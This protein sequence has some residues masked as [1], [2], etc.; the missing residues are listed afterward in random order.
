MLPTKFL[1][2]PFVLLFAVGCDSTSTTNDDAVSKAA[3][4]KQEEQAATDKRI[5]AKKAE[6]LAKD[7]AKEDAIVAKQA[8]VDAICVLPEKL[9][10]KLDKACDEVST[11]HDAFMVRLY[12]EKPETIEKWT[13]GKT[14]QLSMTVAQCK[15]AGSLEVAACQAHALT[16]AGA[17]IKKELPAIFRTCIEKFG[18]PPEPAPK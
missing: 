5:A 12:S 17:E 16:Q 10:K 15:K 4:K 8:A 1:A 2:L 13:A 11:A 14:M 18:T 3:A 7:K 9:P 6:R